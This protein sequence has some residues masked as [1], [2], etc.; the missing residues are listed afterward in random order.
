MNWS[1]PAY[2][3]V[4][5]LVSDRTGLTFPPARRQSAECGIRRAMG[6]A[7]VT[8]VARYGALLAG[9]ADAL[10][11]LIVEL[12]VGETY[13]FREPGQFRFLR[14]TVL[15]EVGRRRGPEHILRAWSAGCAS[16]EEAYSLAILFAQEGLAD[17]AHL[18][19]TDI[20]RS[21]LARARRGVYGDWSL[22][23][24]GAVAV[25][26]FLTR[27][28][29]RYRLDEPIR[30]RVVFEHLNLA[31]DTYPSFA[32][33]TWGMD[34]ILCRN[35]LIYFDPDTVAAVARRLFQA[36]AE[37]GWLITASSDPPLADK[38][39]FE[40]VLAEEGVF[41]RR[42]ENRGQESGVRNQES[43]VRGQEASALAP[44]PR[45]EVSVE[46]VVPEGNFAHSAAAGPVSREAP[47][48]LPP[49]DPKGAARS[50]L[51]RGDYQRAAQLTRDLGGDAEAA[52]LHVR[53]L[54]NLESAA[55][56]QTC[57]AA[58]RRHPLSAEL[59]YLHALLLLELGR[60]AE[61]ARAARR[62]LYLDRG[63]AIAHFTLG[64][65]LRRLGDLAGARR[66]YR[67]ARNLSAGCPEEQLLPLAEG[68]L[69]GRLARAAE[70]QLSLLD[71]PAR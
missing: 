34:L 37:G 63:L 15:P 64:A 71:S 60:D 69:A 21:A 46:R 54:A 52:A 42:P 40:A 70:V 24:E 1:Q 48:A 49:E 33:G 44:A 51:G 27:H 66:A 47:A 55:A 28:G 20:S 59:S 31:L 3:T 25:G 26:P 8:D 29:N 23:D 35:V 36:L 14:H 68:E 65:I 67:N 5:R 2:E 61:A 4:A 50:A 17:R 13:F 16:G 62:V 6:R 19:A 30:R 45:G 41:Y 9:D 22:R 32:T 38:A 12:T 56:E 11:D 7:G 53:A 39:P 58:A 43:G 10:D 18:L 57:A